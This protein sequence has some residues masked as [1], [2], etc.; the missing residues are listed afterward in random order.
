MIY[1]KIKDLKNYSGISKNLDKAIN[2]IL[3]FDTTA[4]EGRYEVDGDN[5][6]VKVCEISNSA[7]TDV[8]EAHKCYAD[9]QV[10]LQGEEYLK[11][12]HIDECVPYKDY[13]EDSDIMFVKGEGNVL[14]VSEGE[15]YLV[16]PEDCHCSYR[17][18]INQTVKKLVVKVRIV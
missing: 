10:V 11:I 7:N 16:Y 18:D 12:A 8:F 6:F 4:P 5:V 13:D 1:G 9:I 14:K 2:C 17:A 3:G 15:F